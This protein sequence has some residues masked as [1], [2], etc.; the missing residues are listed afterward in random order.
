M[1]KTITISAKCSDMF[2][3]RLD[4]GRSYGGYVPRFFPGKHY[5]DYVKLTIELATGKILN[6]TPPEEEAL[7]EV[8]GPTKEA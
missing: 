6:W 1:P 5:G 3:A 7:D 8:F 2:D 4:D